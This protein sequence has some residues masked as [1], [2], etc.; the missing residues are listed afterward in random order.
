MWSISQTYPSATSP[1]P[2]LQRSPAIALL[3]A[4][5]ELFAGSRGPQS[6]SWQPRVQISSGRWWTQDRGL[7]RIW[8]ASSRD[9]IS[10]NPTR[11]VPPSYSKHRRN[12]YCD[13]RRLTKSKAGGGVCLWCVFAPARFCRF[14]FIH[15]L[16]P[17]LAAFTWHRRRGQCERMYDCH[18]PISL[19][20]QLGRLFA[21][22]TTN[23]TRAHTAS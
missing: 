5:R 10:G 21:G 9:Y 22:Q 19:F 16:A 1:P 7:P 14:S 12:W 3:I 17:G 6:C 11:S 15:V 4:L 23:Q 13:H 8:I 18:V 2:A 20:G